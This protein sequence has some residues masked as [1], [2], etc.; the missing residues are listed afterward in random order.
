MSNFFSDMFS[1]VKKPFE[2]VMNPTKDLVKGDFGKMWKDIK[3]IPGSF[4]GGSQDAMKAIGVNGWVGKHPNEAAAAALAAIVGGT[5]AAGAMGA[6]S[7]AGAG[8]SSGGTAGATS[9][10]V[11]GGSSGGV[12]SSLFGVGGA[13]GTTAGGTSAGGSG[14]S[15]QNFGKL[16]SI[17]QQGQGQQDSS[18]ASGAPTPSPYA[19]RSMHINMNR[20]KNPATTALMEQQNEDDDEQDLY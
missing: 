7:A 13:S 1:A 19:V 15:F 5:Y 8:G 12:L 6:T 18:V 16:M 20:F 17:L 2:G 14:M 4:E 11:A 10:S 3:H 9:G